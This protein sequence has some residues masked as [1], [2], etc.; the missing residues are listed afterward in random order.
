M[1][2][3][4]PNDT[5]SGDLERLVMWWRERRSTHACSVAWIASDS[6]DREPA[7]AVDRAVDAGVTLAALAWSAGDVVARSVIAKATG[8][9]ASDVVERQPAASDIQWMRSVSQ[10][11]DL[12]ATAHSDQDLA[13]L[14]EGLLRAGERELPVLFDGVAAH[15]A[16]VIAA[17]QDSSKAYWWLPVS[18]STDPAIALAQRELGVSPALDL[19][20]DGNGT[21]AL[22][23]AVALLDVFDPPEETPSLIP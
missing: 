21:A 19:H 6:A 7:Q 5:L 16:A 1:R 10:V 12:G 4:D 14:V 8:S 20:T 15:A 2:T 3:V 18:S 17:Q 9:P 11:R 22:Q 23:A 13:S